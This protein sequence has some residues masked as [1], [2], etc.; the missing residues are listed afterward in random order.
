MLAQKI[1]RFSGEIGWPPMEK[2]MQN[3]KSKLDID[4]PS[5]LQDLMS[6]PILSLRVANVL[7]ANKVEHVTDLS[8]L[9]PD[10]LVHMLSLS[11]AFRI[12]VM[13]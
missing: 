5:T 8:I 10:R 12:N 3:F 4:I 11:L 9:Q 7:H 2:L 6:I 1:Q 13:S